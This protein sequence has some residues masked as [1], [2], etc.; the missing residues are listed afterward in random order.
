MCVILYF[1][2]NCFIICYIYCLCLVKSSNLHCRV[3]H[4]LLFDVVISS[5]WVVSWWSVF[6]AMCLYVSMVKVCLVVSFY[7]RIVFR[8][9]REMFEFV[10]IFPSLFCYFLEF[11]VRIFWHEFPSQT[12][13]VEI[14]SC[15]TV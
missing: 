5:S 7:I 4:I 9:L 6:V 11:Y 2:L 1:I 13:F 15:I 14:Y 3:C 12:R 8:F 10:F